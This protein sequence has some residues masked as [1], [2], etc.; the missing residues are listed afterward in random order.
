VKKVIVGILEEIKAEEN[1][2]SMVPANVGD[3]IGT[4]VQGV[5]NRNFCSN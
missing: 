3:E 4:L 1:L 2:V 5:L